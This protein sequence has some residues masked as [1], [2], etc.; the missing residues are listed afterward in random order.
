MHHGHL[1]AMLQRL[2]DQKLYKKLSKCSFWQ[3]SI[4]FLRL[5]VSDQGV[6][7]D[8][9]KIKAI[10]EWPRPKNALEIRSFFGLAG[11]Y[12]K[13]MN[14]VSS[15]AKSLTRL[16]GKDAKFTWTEEWEKEFLRA[17]GNVNKRTGSSLTRNR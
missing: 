7:V 4:G 14:G 13:F 16:T 15:L 6:S 5:I 8:L 11:Y 1:R 10:E 3:R 2:R 17:E 9:E 12:R